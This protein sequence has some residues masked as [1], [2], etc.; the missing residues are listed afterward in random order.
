MAIG[1]PVLV[2]D[3]KNNEPD[4]SQWIA[5]KEILKKAG[6]DFRIRMGIRMMLTIGLLEKRINEQTKEEEYRL[7]ANGIARGLSWKSLGD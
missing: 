2:K 3:Y 5:R 6:L 7:T 4:L 1:E